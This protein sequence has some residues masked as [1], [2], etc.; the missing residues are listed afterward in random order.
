M[1]SDC[2]ID[3]TNNHVKIGLKSLVSRGRKK[4]GNDKLIL[5]FVWS[6]R[7]AGRFYLCGLHFAEIRDL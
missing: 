4:R 2:M 5:Y 1:Q 3:E 6:N 7:R